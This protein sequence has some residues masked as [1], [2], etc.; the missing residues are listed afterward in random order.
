MGHWKFQMLAAQYG[1]EIVFLDMMKAVAQMNAFH[2]SSWNGSIA[3]WLRF[4]VLDMIPDPVDRL[5]WIDSDTIVEGGLE[6]IVDAIP[7]T[8]PLPPCAIVSHIASDYIWGLKWMSHTSMQV[9]SYLTC[10]TC[11][12]TVYL[13]KLCATLRKMQ[14][15]I[16]RQIR[17]MNRF[18]VENRNYI[19]DTIIN[20]FLKAYSIEDYF[21]VYP[22][23]TEAYYTPKQ[24]LESRNPRS[25]FIFFASWGIILGSRERTTIQQSTCTTNGSR[26][27]YG[28][29]IR[30]WRSGRN[31]SSA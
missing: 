26:N 21:C 19:L 1:R 27:H 3:T 24:I 15:G 28:K 5:I 7:T 10:R 18:F 8:A 29:T 6:R 2:C 25:S 12:E 17:Y 22:W 9:S 31:C 11:A 4:F 14:N 13:N 23:L 30:V 20:V 16:W